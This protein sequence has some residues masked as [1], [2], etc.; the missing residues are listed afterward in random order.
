M[1]TAETATAT[2]AGTTEPTWNRTR[3]EKFERFDREGWAARS[4][5]YD[6]GFARLTAGVHPVLLDRAGVVAGTRTLEVGCGSGRLSAAALARGAEVVATDAVPGMVEVAV[7]ALPHAEVRL[8]ALPDLPFVDGEFDAVVGA[9][10]INHVPEPP[11]AV[12]ELVRVTRPGGRVVLSC[13]DSAELNRAQS[14]FFDAA[15]EAGAATPVELP[16]GSPFQAHAGAEGFARLLRDAGLEDVAVEPV[17]WTH[18]VA[19]DQ[20]WHDILAGTVLT[21]ALVRGQ[22]PATV[23]RIRAAYDRLVAQYAVSDDGVSEYAVGDN[24]VGDMGV[25]DNGVGDDRDGATVELP[26][27]A[28]VATG[29]RPDA[30][31]AADTT[32]SR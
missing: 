19:P 3:L 32:A 29:V 24:G 20:W 15:A 17:S 26:V 4:A 14:V 11:A 18:R 9:F 8:A 5:T 2:T 23:R 28:L 25:G 21:S 1:T 30:V 22:D 16:A 6:S 13:W 12:A 27:A 31:A 7:N 10:V